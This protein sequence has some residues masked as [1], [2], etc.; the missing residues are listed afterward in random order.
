MTVVCF[1]PL[2]YAY[3]S[4]KFCA[5]TAEQILVPWKSYLNRSQ[6]WVINLLSFP[7][8]GLRNQLLQIHL[9]YQQ[10]IRYLLAPSNNT[11]QLSQIY[12]FNSHLHLIEGNPWSE[13]FLLKKAEL[14]DWK[15]SLLTLKSYFMERLTLLF[16]SLVQ[17]AT[18]LVTLQKNKL[19]FSNLTHLPVS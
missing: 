14:G 12:A 3:G 13:I 2:K 19:S 11:G 5:C 18:L 4:W 16:E 8:P 1:L 9:H 7:K 10:Y 6:C 15:F 17:F